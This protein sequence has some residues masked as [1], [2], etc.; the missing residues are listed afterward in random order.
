MLFVIVICFDPL[1]S[2]TAVS[3][4]SGFAG[5]L[6]KLNRFA[7]PVPLR[8]KVSVSAPSSI[9]S[10]PVSGPVEVGVYRTSTVHWSPSLVSVAPEQ[11]SL[12]DG[13]SNAGSSD[14]TVSIV[15]A[16]PLG[17]LKRLRL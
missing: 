3:G 17:M 1:V 16:P 12:P 13:T 7:T 15:R 4:K 5:L 6:V 2:P 8:E 10:V 9:V 11:L 14:V